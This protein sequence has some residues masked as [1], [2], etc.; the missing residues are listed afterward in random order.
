MTNIFD[1]RG[2]LLPLLLRQSSSSHHPLDRDLR[3]KI[4]DGGWHLFSCYR[5]NPRC[6]SH[7]RTLCS[8]EWTL[9]TWL[10]DKD[11]RIKDGGSADTSFS[12]RKKLNLHESNTF[13]AEGHGGILGRHT[14]APLASC[15]FV[16]FAWSDIV[17]HLMIRDPCLF[18]N[19]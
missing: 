8:R 16:C 2:P 4:M 18:A 1:I 9:Y 5:E 11:D 14:D 10:E 15:G 19:K 6:C 12:G 7:L 17:G 3:S 13:H